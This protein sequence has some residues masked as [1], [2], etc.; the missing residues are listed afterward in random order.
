MQT[1]RQ[2]IETSWIIIASFFYHCKFSM[3][4]SMVVHQWS[5]DGMLKIIIASP[6]R[7]GITNLLCSFLLKPYLYRCG[8][9]MVFWCFLLF[10]TQLQ[11]R[12]IYLTHI[13]VIAYL[14]RC[15]FSKISKKPYLYQSGIDMFFSIFSLSN[16]LLETH[17]RSESRSLM[18]TR[19]HGHVN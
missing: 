11:L 3:P 16:F 8:I 2:K 13:H 19:A 9:D 7:G 6:P 15:F 18:F 1:W 4:F 14:L 17:R 12:H 10:L 5:D